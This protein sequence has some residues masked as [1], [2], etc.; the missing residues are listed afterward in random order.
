MNDIGRVHVQHAA[1]QLVGEVLNM[2]VGQI[3]VT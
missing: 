3:L 2:I 1:K